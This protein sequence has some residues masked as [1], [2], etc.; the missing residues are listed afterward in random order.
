LL[1]ERAHQDRP[2]EIDVLPALLTAD[3]P[4]DARLRLA[5]ADEAL[6]FRRGRLRPRGDDLHLI[7]VAQLRAKR[8]Q[9]PVDLGTRAMVADLGMHGVGEIDRGGLA[10]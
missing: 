1:A 3:H 9:A 8:Q 10:G 6:P 2:A 4:A 7:T 5:G